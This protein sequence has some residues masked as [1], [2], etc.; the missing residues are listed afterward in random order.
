MDRRDKLLGIVYILHDVIS[1]P[2]QAQFQ[3][4]LRWPRIIAGPMGIDKLL[5]RGGNK[6]LY[7]MEQYVT[8]LLLKFTPL[9]VFKPGGVRR[10]R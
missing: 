7:L 5:R 6:A 10:S 1:Q 3:A 9:Q 2:K 8:N 4:M